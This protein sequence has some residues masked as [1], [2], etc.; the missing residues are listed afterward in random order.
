MKVAAR[1]SNDV[2][3][4]SVRQEHDA[5]RD[6]HPDDTDTR[7]SPT[8]VIVVVMHDSRRF[9]ISSAHKVSEWSSEVGSVPARHRRPSSSS[10]FSLY[11]VWGL[12]TRHINNT[13]TFI[14]FSSMNRL[15]NVKNC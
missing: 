6:Q 13:Q 1:S 4:G 8:T 7:A 5:D 11:F 15:R 14:I 3:E 2:A 10:E 12:S 9:F